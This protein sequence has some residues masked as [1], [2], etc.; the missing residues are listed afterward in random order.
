[1]KHGSTDEADARKA[2]HFTGLDS[3]GSGGAVFAFNAP[4]TLEGTL[5]AR[6]ADKVGLG[7]HSHFLLWI[8]N[9][10]LRK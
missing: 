4:L 1:M 6:F 8:G 10:C 2:G 9:T 5:P 3:I 7:P